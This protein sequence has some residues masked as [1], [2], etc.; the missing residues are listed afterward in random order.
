MFNIQPGQ[1]LGFSA[2]KQIAFGLGTSFLIR[3]FGRGVLKLTAQTKQIIIK[4]ITRS[5]IL[6][7]Q[8]KQIIVKSIT[9]QGMLKLTA[10]T[11]QIIVKTIT[12]RP[13]IVTVIKKSVIKT[14]VEP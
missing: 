7:A 9:G 11:K 8:T 5:S 1:G 4:S 14:T 12:K 3:E 10:Q 2:S 6:I 13:T